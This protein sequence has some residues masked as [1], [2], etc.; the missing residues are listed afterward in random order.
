MGIDSSALIESPSSFTKSRLLFLSKTKIA[1]VLSF[2]NLLHAS[3]KSSIFSLAF[4]S[5]ILKNRLNFFQYDLLFV[6]LD[7]PNNNKNFLISC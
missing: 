2:F 1:P 4:S 5:L 6:I 7:E 3:K